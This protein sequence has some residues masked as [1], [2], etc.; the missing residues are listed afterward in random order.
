MALNSVKGQ[1]TWTWNGTDGNGNTLPD[2]SYKVAVVGA[3]TDGTTSALPFS[4]VGTAT[5]VLSQ[6]NG[7]QLELGALT[8]DFSAVQS[9]G[10]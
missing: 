6:S 9:V 2:G 4:V 8:V 1:N 7:M 10:N 5:G 3:N